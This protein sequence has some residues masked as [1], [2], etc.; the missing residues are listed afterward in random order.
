MSSQIPLQI[1][2]DNV[3]AQIARA[4]M[5]AELDAINLYEQM[6]NITD[7]PAFKKI[8]VDISDEEKVHAGEFLELLS[9]V[10]LKPYEHQDFALI[11][12]GEAEAK[13]KMREVL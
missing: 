10:T 4:G 12:S 11:S 13:K 7:N 2:K 8:L 5:I 6:A 3:D 9:S 1:K